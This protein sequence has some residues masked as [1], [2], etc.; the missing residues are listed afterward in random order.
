MSKKSSNATAEAQLILQLYDLRREA[1][2]R[3]ARKWAATEFWP[4]SADDYV[5]VFFAMDTPESAWLRQVSTYWSMAAAFALQGAVDSDMFLQPAISGEMMFLFAKVHPFLKDL[6]K[7]TGDS[8][9]YSTIEKLVTGSKYGRERLKLT[10]ER[11]RAMQE[12]RA[13]SR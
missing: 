4:K 5:E 11:V 12:K 10:A 13:K 8:Q 9:T 6:R 7:K 2:M 3:K 1:E